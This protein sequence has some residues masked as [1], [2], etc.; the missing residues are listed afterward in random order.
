[1]VEERKRL[2]VRLGQICEDQLEDFDAAIDVYARLLREDPREEDTW[3]TLTRLAK[4]G[5]QWNRLGKI[6][7]RAFDDQNATDEATRRLAKY[8]ARIFAERVGN[9]HRAA[10]LLEKAL[11]F[12]PR[13]VE[14]FT[15]LEAAYRQTA[16]HEKLLQLYREQIDGEDDD[17]RR[18]KLLHERARIY[19]DT[20][21]L[22]LE[23][24]ASYREILELDPDNRDATAGLETL[25]T[26]GEDWT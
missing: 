13:D 10:Q 26:Q 22:P 9:H 18:V 1:D 17:E 12:D 20:L 3:E 2:L 25:L 11:A 4:V 24:I 6:L 15:A 19:R 14:A 8:T 21:T 5:S 16:S 23:A 7:E